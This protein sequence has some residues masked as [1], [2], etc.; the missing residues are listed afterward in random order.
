MTVS[1]V[2]FDLGD[3]LWHFPEMPPVDTIRKETVRRISNLL[4]LWNINPEGEFFFIGRDIRLA[5]DKAERAAYSSDFVSPNY[6]ELTRDVAAAKGLELTLDQ[7]QELWDAWNL[8]GEF[9]GRTLFDDTMD[10]L[11]TLRDRGYQI[12]CVTN[13]SFGGPRFLDEVRNLG[14]M[15]YF[16]TMVVSCDFGYMKPHPEIYQEA[17]T[18]LNAQPEETAMVGD[19][20]KADVAGAQVLGLTGIWRKRPIVRDEPADVTPDYTVDE[21]NEIPGLACFNGRVGAG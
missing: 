2:L 13:R 5:L 8:G 3:T 15:D 7:S 20:L 1:T 9:F 6:S 21:L 17:L 10:M 11:E 4:R 14:L 16:D 12:G 19:S 18:N